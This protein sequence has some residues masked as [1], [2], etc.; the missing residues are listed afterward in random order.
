[1][2]DGFGAGA[3]FEDR[4]L[5]LADGFGDADLAGA[6]LGAV[7]DGAAAPHPLAVVQDVQPLEPTGPCCRDDGPRR[8]QVQRPVRPLMMP[9][10]RS[11]PPRPPPQAPMSW[12]LRTPP[13]L[14]RGSHQGLETTR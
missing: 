12:S 11:L 13:I 2:A 7:E 3:A 1:V 5:H 6:G 9:W 4:L 10:A 14:Q 8:R